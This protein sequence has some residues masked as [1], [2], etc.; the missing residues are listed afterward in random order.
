M[1]LDGTPMKPS[2]IFHIGYNKVG[3]SALQAQLMDLEASGALAN[4]SIVYPHT[5]RT[6]NSNNFL[7]TLV[8]T[9]KEKLET[10]GPA[11]H[12][13]IQDIKRCKTSHDVTKIRE[14]KK[15]Q[16]FL[17]EVE[18]FDTV[19]LSTEAAFFEATPEIIH[20][21][22]GNEFEL[23]IVLYVRSPLR[24]M[25]SW[26]QYNINH[27]IKTTQLGDF[28][29]SNSIDYEYSIEKWHNI[30]REKLLV[31]QYDTRD[32][33]ENGIVRAF[34]KL[35]ELPD[36]IIVNEKTKIYNPNISGNLLFCRQ[37]INHFISKQ[38]ASNLNSLFKK[39]AR[40]DNTFSGPV[41]VD[42]ELARY[43]IGRNHRS[44]DYLKDRHGFTW[45]DEKGIQGNLTPDFS[46]LS[47]DVI[48]ITEC[49]TEEGHDDAKWLRELPKVL[50]NFYPDKM[51]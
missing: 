16:A 44:Y 45:I 37:L 12:P 1:A 25:V 38:E 14:A 35:S 51:L 4:H 13:L 30:F 28:L 17:D 15:Y 32:I 39:V 10:P 22:F 18:G 20:E 24:H 2:M 6:Q 5:W 48:K 29:W 33:K 27:D 26:W 9:T 43:F 46:R 36:S 42:E 3:T 31:N 8:N 21:L 47:D 49:L 50:K 34:W 11:H 7:Q 19:I 23:R 41:A 40:I